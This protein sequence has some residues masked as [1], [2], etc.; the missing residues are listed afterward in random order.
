MFWDAAYSRPSRRGNGHCSKIP[1][2]ESFSH[3]VQQ[4]VASLP[5][6]PAIPI[7]GD[8]NLTLLDCYT[9]GVQ[10]EEAAQR[11][12]RSAGWT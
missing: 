5:G 7:E 8:L 9:D 10:A 11:I 2:A 12:R 4:I 6:E 3:C 1:L